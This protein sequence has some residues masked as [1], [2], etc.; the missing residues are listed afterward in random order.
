MTTVSCCLIITCAHHLDG[1]IAQLARACG[2]YPQ[3]HWFKSSCRYHAGRAFTR[4]VFHTVF[5][6]ARPYCHPMNVVLT[7]TPRH[8]AK[9]KFIVLF[10]S[11]V[12]P[13][14]GPVVK[15]LRLRPFTAATRVRVPSGSP[16]ANNPNFLIA[17]KYF[18]IIV[19][20]A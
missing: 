1:G 7:R 8:F 16:T 6:S 18:G 20:L 17:G 13:Y 5:R 9:V 19:K 10:Y 15:R 12:Y 11:T 3:C 14:N 4:P 2:S